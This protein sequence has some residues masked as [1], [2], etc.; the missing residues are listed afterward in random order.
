MGLLVTLGVI[1]VSGWFLYFTISKKVK[2]ISKNL[3]GTDNFIEGLNQISEE[4][5]NTPYSVSG[6]NTLYLPKVQSDFPDYHRETMEE[7]VKEF[8]LLYFKS[9]EERKLAEFNKTPI[10]STVKELIDSKVTD[11]IDSNK[12]EKHDNI[13]IHAITIYNY[14]KTTE[15]ATVRYQVSLEYLGNNGKT[16]CKYE[17][18]L[19]YLFKDIDKDSFSVRCSHCG[20]SLI[21]TGLECEYCGTIIVRNITKVWT[22][23]N[24][25]K[26]K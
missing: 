20:G 19:T 24:F 1:V 14:T 7:K 10:S 12:T 3:L 11:L 5:K 22:V 21:G 25:K 13:K 6:G 15:L 8:A 17:I 18:D 26:I 9:I 4:S 2:N 23:S 16:Q